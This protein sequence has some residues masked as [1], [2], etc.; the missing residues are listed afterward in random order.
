MKPSLMRRLRPALFATLIASCIALPAAARAPA[1]ATAP[2]PGN[3]V[4]RIGATLLDQQ[5]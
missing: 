5:G 4:Y 2:L 1:D 3:S